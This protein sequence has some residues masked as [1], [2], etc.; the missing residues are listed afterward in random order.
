MGET[1][2]GKCNEITLKIVEF[3]VHLGLS[4]LKSVDYTI[5]KHRRE[6]QTKDV[7]FS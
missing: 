3:Q 1:G 5:L 7:S 6:V 4:Y 2:L